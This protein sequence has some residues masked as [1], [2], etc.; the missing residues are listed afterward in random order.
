VPLPA[1]T[2]P[3]AYL[4][5]FEGALERAFRDCAPQLVLVSAGYDCLAGD[6]LG[7]LLLEPADI[8]A[9]TRSLMRRAAAAGAPVAIMLEGG[10]APPRVGSGVVATM[11]ALAGVAY[12]S[13]RAGAHSPPP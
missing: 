12:P 6:P 4:E 2:P 1:G 9:M 11:R 7:G 5:A 10:Y 8:H 3:A 13:G